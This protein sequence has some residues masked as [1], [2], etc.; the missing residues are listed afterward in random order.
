LALEQW[1]HAGGKDAEASIKIDPETKTLSTTAIIFDKL[2]WVSPR[3][4][5]GQ[6]QLDLLAKDASGGIA[7]EDIWEALPEEPCRYTG[8]HGSR[9]AYTFSL[10]CGSH[11]HRHDASENLLRHRKLANAYLDYAKHLTSAETKANEVLKKDAREFENDFALFAKARRFLVSEK[12]FY[13]LSAQL[14]KEGDVL[15]VIPGIR[16]TWILRPVGENYRYVGAA[17]V[18][19]VMRGELLEEKDPLGLNAGSPKEII[20]F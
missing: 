3:I 17:Y 13:G 20:I 5:E 15:A 19:G 4:Q 18:H 1:F 10:V 6:V 14:A 7:M 2:V 16:V 12:G 11:G 9:D 8:K